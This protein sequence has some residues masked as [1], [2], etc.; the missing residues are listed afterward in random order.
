MRES[1]A[2]EEADRPIVRRSATTAYMD[3]QVYTFFNACLVPPQAVR[4]LL[5]DAT[6]SGFKIHRLFYKV[7]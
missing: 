6:E 1:F 3:L 2:L 7:S 5:T 4:Y